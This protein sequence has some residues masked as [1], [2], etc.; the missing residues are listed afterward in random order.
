[1]LNGY[2]ERGISLDEFN[3]ELDEFVKEASIFV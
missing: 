2:A 1:M 3:E